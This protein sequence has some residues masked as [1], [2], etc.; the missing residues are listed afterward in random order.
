MS[1]LSISPYSGINAIAFSVALATSSLA[2][3]APWLDTQDPYLKASITALANGG[4]IKSPINTYPL[5]YKSIAKDLRKA[6]KGKIPDNLQFALQH[7]EHVLQ[8]NRAPRTTGIKLKTATK[9][10]DFQSFGERHSAKGEVNIFNEFIGKNWAAKSSVH[11][12]TDAYNN[13]SRSYEGSYLAAILG[14]WIVSVDQ[15]SQWWGP[16]NDTVL[17]L[18]NNAVAF[19][20]VRFSRH[21]AAPINLPI[22]NWLGPISM[23]TYFGQQEHSNVRKNI[24]TWGARFN[25]KPI[26]TLE[27]GF[28]RTAQWGGA[29]RPRGFS[30][31]VDLLVGSDNAGVNADV[32]A[33]TEPGN[34]LAGVDFKWSPLLFNQP[35]SVYGEVIGEDESGGLPSHTIFQLG[36]ETSFG[37]RDSIYHAFAEY[38]D[39][40]TN[41]NS[42]SSTGNCAYEHH[43]YREGYRRYGRS[44]GSTYDNDANV[45]TLGLSQSKVGGVS[46]YSKL[47]WMKLNKDNQNSWTGVNPIS[48][49]A[50]DRL[51]VEGG[52]RFPI[53]KGLLN[54]QATI[55]HN[56]VK[57]TGDTDTKGIVKASWE[58]RF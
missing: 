47:K 37:D 9:T 50:Q 36:M 24:R 19:P 32:T 48:P 23:T 10:N 54:V 58:Y 16:G 41:C 25:F 1:N 12:T 4:I 40:F 57:I 13:K 55:Y 26:D 49:V 15:L 46:W 33:A 8:H 52:Y 18:S 53:F 44:M 14:N 20:A 22:L 56:K 39:T 45:F 5:M 27:I 38:T 42:D 34:Q 30:T 11:F 6:H 29:G 31:F 51:Q 21:S 3:A 28:T 7:V 43:I 35:F 2:T 17:A